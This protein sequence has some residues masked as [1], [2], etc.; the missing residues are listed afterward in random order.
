MRLRR[1]RFS[2]CCSRVLRQAC[3][4]S[5]FRALLPK[6]GHGEWKDLSIPS[7]IESGQIVLAPS[8]PT[9]NT[10]VGEEMIC[11]AATASRRRSCCFADVRGA[12]MD[13]SMRASSSGRWAAIRSERLQSSAGVTCSLLPCGIKANFTMAVRRPASL[14]ACANEGPCCR[15]VPR[16]SRNS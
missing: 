13:I 12:A 9:A 3:G 7:V 5:S 16:R 6:L 15:D 14:A 11:F 1:V 8:T 4:M 10:R 2:H